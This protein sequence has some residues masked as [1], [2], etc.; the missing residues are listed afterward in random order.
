M[1]EVAIHSKTK[2]NFLAGIC[3]FIV[4]IIVYVV[5]SEI[6]HIYNPADKIV[7][8][9]YQIGGGVRA[10]LTHNQSGEIIFL[11]DT[12][13][14]LIRFITGIVFSIVISLLFGLS[15]GLFKTVEKYLLKPILF[16]GKIPPLALLP[17]IFVFAGLGEATKILLIIIG[18][19]PAITL[20]IYFHIKQMSEDQFIKA[21]T[22]GA[23]KAATI[24]KIVLPQLAPIL[25]N[26]IRVNIINVWVYLIAVE[27]ISA[28]C[29]LGY[30][31]FL[32]RRY[33]AMNI[34]IPYVIWIA[35]LSFITDFALNRF[36]KKRFPWYYNS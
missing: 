20:D 21:K 24:F 23:N 33:L 31:I 25:I 11:K 34:I 1:I 12:M 13:A 10:T 3:L 5:V 27:S 7:P 8:T 29:G 28:S 15:I 32:V 35:I 26:S 19:C 6:R 4:I 16:F 17:I 9:L 14:S 2:N 30:R 18:I 22:L 36:S